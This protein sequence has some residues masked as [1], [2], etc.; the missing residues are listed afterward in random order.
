MTQTS[1]NWLGAR[2]AALLAALAVAPTLTGATTV[3]GAPTSPLTVFEASALIGAGQVTTGQFTIPVAGTVSVTLRDMEW[4]ERFAALSFCLVEGTNI[5]LQLTQP[6]TETF[7]IDR[8]LSFFAFVAGTP[9][10]ASGL[11]LYSLQ[12][13]ITPVPLPA[14]GLLLLSGVAGLAFLRRRRSTS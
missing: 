1:R 4:P 3:A 11:G 6:G 2:A 13:A 10:H 9:Q 12:I 8:P 5:V 14:A 7:T